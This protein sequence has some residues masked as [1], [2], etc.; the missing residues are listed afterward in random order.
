MK[1]SETKK[2][3][4]GKYMYR[5]TFCSPLAHYFHKT[6]SFN[7]TIKNL[8]KIINDAQEL[9]RKYNAPAKIKRW[10]RHYTV[11]ADHLHQLEK[12]K[13]ILVEY[14]GEFRS[15]TEMNNVSVYTND[16]KMINKIIS[17]IDNKDITEVIKPN[18]NS[19]HILEENNEVYIVNKPSEYKYRVI[20]SGSVQNSKNLADWLENNKEKIKAS[21]CA[22]NGFKF[23]YWMSNLIFY[24]R[25]DK[26]LT[27]A[28]MMLGKNIK[29]V[30]KLIFVGD[31][32]ASQQNS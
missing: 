30:Q 7:A 21:S 1:Q 14:D 32:A 28:Q 27:M 29:Q 19:K 26:V 10:N 6:S 11:D 25:D 31:A 3:F 23:E 4:F 20:V 8:E 22:I 13:D 9:I 2:L 15:R 18:P 24:V 5:I 16:E 17:S 12:F